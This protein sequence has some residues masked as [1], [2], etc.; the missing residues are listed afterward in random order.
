MQDTPVAAIVGAAPV[1]Y[2]QSDRPPR[3]DYARDGAVQADYTCPQT[4][5]PI[6]RKTT[7]PI[8]A[9]TSVRPHWCPGAPAMS[10]WP[11]CPRWA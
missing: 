9:C 3:G 4:T 8:G 2:G 11:P 7:T 10:S 1:V 5:R 6:P